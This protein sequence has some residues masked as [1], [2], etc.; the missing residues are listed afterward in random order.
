MKLAYKA[1]FLL[2]LGCLL[3][4][5]ATA[6]DRPSQEFSKSIKKEFAISS[7]GTAAMYNQ[8]G[9]IDVKTWQQNRVKVEV[10]ITV[11]ARNE[12][13]AQKV[14]DRIKVEFEDRADYVKAE[15]LIESSQNSWWNWGSDKSE[16]SIDYE[17]FVPRSLQL[18][19][20]NK[21]GDVYVGEMDGQGEVR[22]KYGN[23]RL[24]GFNNDLELELAYG[25]GAVVKAK[26]I[27]ADLSY[28]KLTMEQV[29]DL[30]VDSKYS[31]LTIEQCNDLR[32]SSKYDTYEIGALHELRSEGRYDNLRI[33]KAEN[34]FVNSR[35]TDLKIERIA[36]SADLDLQYG[37]VNI[38]E[39]AKGFS[40]VRLIGR[41]TD[42]KV[43]VEDGASYQLEAT[44]DYAGIIYPQ[45]MNI[46]YEKDKGTYHEVEGHIGAKGA[47]SVIKARLDYGGLKVVH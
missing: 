10:T 19:L 8:Y 33:G 16:F 42:Y 47:R 22:V 46:T 38:G 4:S 30:V 27:N 13:D 34:L 21:Y 23:F 14:F 35:Y 43:R 28:G 24:E 9:K 5:T 37:G 2:F 17:V 18:D 32:S 41:Y 12:S 20:Q 25:N 26:D 29:R 45:N 3:A 6:S 40:E 1:G 7:N 11:E 44:G 15:T 39:I 31:M 36:N